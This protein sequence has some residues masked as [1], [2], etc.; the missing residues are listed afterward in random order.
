MAEM[1]TP[2]PMT[3]QKRL[4]WLA[5]ILAVQ[6]L[7]FPINRGVQGGRVLV[8]P[9]DALVPIWP[10]WVVPYLLA[11]AWW[12]GCFVWAAW[13]MDD[14][15]Y[16]ALVVAALAVMLSSYAV[17]I[18]FPTYVERP[19]L[20]GRGWA[21][22]LLQSLYDHDRVN[23]AFPSGHTYTTVLI[24]LFWW[25]WRPRLRWLWITIALVIVLSTLFSGQHHLVDPVGGA[26][27]AWAGYRFGLW[28][29]AR[30]GPGS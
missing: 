13:K 14:D 1:R 11:I 7:Y 18:F 27:W 26:I 9:W 2:A 8:T 24:V 17:F 19:V 23:N 30:R 3:W 29:V 4:L 12:L 15:L 10:I 6:W 28:W 25:R 22:D 21:V 16:R 20:E 5:V